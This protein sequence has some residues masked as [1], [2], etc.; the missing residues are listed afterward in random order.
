MKYSLLIVNYKT[1]DDVLLLLQDVWDTFKNQP[2]EVL[3][4]DNASGD[5][6]PESLEK[7]RV[8]Y[9]SENAGFGKAMN[10]AASEARGEYLVLIN[11]DCRLPADQDFDMFV[12]EGEKMG[13]GVL[14]PLIRYPNGDLQPNRGGYSTLAT[15]IF[16]ALRLGRLRKV[17]PSWVGRLPI[18]RTSIIGKYLNN[19]EPS[20]PEYEYCDWV[21]GAFMVIKADVFRKVS[22]FDENFFMY[23]EDEDLCLRIAKD[24]GKSLFS[25]NFLVVHE[26]GGAQKSDVDQRLKTI[27]I[28]RLESNIYFTKKHISSVSSLLIRYFYALLYISLAFRLSSISQLFSISVRFLKK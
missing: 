19:F 27:E 6:F 24:G 20:I 7:T 5:C 3:I 22:G 10:L 28:K 16:Q 23:C 8:I 1:K 4:V 9:H 11:P 14:A 13:F 17:I 18:I 26:V 21:S 15:F 12:S 2:Y 25:S